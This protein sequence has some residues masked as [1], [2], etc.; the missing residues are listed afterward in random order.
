MRQLWL[1]WLWRSVPSVRV[2]SIP[3]PVTRYEMRLWSRKRIHWVNA[4]PSSASPYSV[5]FA[6]EFPRRSTFFSLENKSR[7]P[8]SLML[9]QRRWWR[10]GR[11]LG[12]VLF[13]ASAQ[14]GVT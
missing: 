2:T 7:T 4:L 14:G 10:D 9:C 6:F 1:I 3:F 13:H 8:M 11:R 12:V 5:R